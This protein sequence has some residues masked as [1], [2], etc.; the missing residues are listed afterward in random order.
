MTSS[1]PTGWRVALLTVH[2]VASVGAIGAALV[3]L[4]LGIAGVLGA[5]PRTVYPAAH[6][7][8]AQVIAPLA[9][10]A[11]VSGLVQALLSR[12]GL[13]R[14][15]WVAIKLALNIV[16]VALVPI[17]LRPEVV[18][19]AEQGR[20]FMDGM[21]AEFGLGDL[22]FPPIVAPSAMLVAMI[23]AVFKP[24]GPIRKREAPAR[25]VPVRD[26]A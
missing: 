9:V 17:A 12:W 16:L 23:L 14:Y 3:L 13:I 24:W 6:L 20:R 11:L 1:R 5:D 22:I 21:P 25:K 10:L 2:V 4:T 18:D 15:W 8:E 19:M 26:A 7:V